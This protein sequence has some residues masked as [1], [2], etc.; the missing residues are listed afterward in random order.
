VNRTARRLAATIRRLPGTTAF[1]CPA[2]ALETAAPLIGCTP[3]NAL[4]VI[5]HGPDGTF[6]LLH[7]LPHPD[8]YAELLSTL[9][10]ELAGKRADAIILI[11]YG[12]HD[13][14]TPVL[15]AVQETFGDLVTITQAL[16][17]VD[18]QQGTA[19]TDP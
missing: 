4:V 8:R 17:V 11:A 1:G 19:G 2:D 6:A 12:S 18:D 16:L 5:C 13:T 14:A 15:R 9:D 10:G 7:H 3:R